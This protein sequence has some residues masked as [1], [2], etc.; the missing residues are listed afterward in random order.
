MYRFRKDGN[1]PNGSLKSPS[2]CTPQPLVIIAYVRPVPWV[3]CG[4]MW[5]VIFP[6]VRFPMTEA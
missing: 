5:T 4:C 1:R 2:R 6:A 3:M